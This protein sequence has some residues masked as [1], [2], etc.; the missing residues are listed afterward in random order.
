ERLGLQVADVAGEP[1][2][3]LVLQLGAGDRNL[4]RVDHDDVVAGV[5][6]RGVDGLVLAAQAAGELGGE[7][8]EGLPSASTR[9]QSRWTVSFLALK[10]FMAGRG[11]LV[12]LVP[13]A[14]GRGGTSPR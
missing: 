2:V 10:V 4:L 14:G 11:Y 3:H 9:Y 12:G 13:R 5:D 1:V 6:V 8:S 7:A